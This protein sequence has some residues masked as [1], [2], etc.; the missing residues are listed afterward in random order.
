MHT[1]KYTHI[2]AI[3][4]K[5][6]H[7]CK[8]ICA[9]GY[10]RRCCRGATSKTHV[11]HDTFRRDSLIHKTNFWKCAYIHIYHVKYSCINLLYKIY[12]YVYTLVQAAICGDVV[13]VLRETC[14]MTQNIYICIYIGAYIWCG[15]LRRCC[16]GLRETGT[17]DMTHLDA[18]VGYIRQVSEYVH[19]YVFII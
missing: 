17:C 3:L 10:L 15:Y 16:R 18:T 9:G 13:V 2:I 11:Q 1:C 8:Y 19:I 5:N 6:M 12:I 7:I 14:D 4:Y